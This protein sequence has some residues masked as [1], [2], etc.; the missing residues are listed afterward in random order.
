MSGSREKICNIYSVFI[1]NK[2]M[3]RHQLENQ[4]I[5]WHYCNI[6]DAWCWKELKFTGGRIEI[7]SKSMSLYCDTE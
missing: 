3:Y 5:F 2:I 1:E 7:P 6:G 4:T